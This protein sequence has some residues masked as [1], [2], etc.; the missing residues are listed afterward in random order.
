MKISELIRLNKELRF[1]KAESKTEFTYTD[2]ILNDLV[3]YLKGLVFVY[4]DNSI[5]GLSSFF[6]ALESEA[7]IVLLSSKLPEEFKNRIE[8]IYQP[9]FIV[10]SIRDS[11]SSYQKQSFSTGAVGISCFNR[12]ENRDQKD[13][14]HGDAAQI[15]PEIKILLSTSGTTGSP[16]LVKLS[17]ENLVS[18]TQSILGY[19]PIDQNDVAPLNL[20]IFYSYGLSILLTNS[21]KGGKILVTQQ[22]FLTRKFW[23]EYNEFQCNSF[24]GVPVN[25]EILDRIGFRSWQLQ[26]LKYFTQAGGKLSEMLIEKFTEYATQSNAKF[27]V[28]YGATEATARMSYLPPEFLQSKRGSIGIAIPDGNL[29]ID[30]TTQELKYKGPNVFGGYSENL[31]DLNTW[32]QPEYL[33]TGDLARK[34]EDGF[35][36]ITGRIK[37]IVKLSGNRINLDEIEQY[38][39]SKSDVTFKVIG[40]DDKYMSLYYVQHSSNEL[41]NSKTGV[42]NIVNN[43]S[44]N[45]INDEAKSS[46]KKWLQVDFKIHPTQVKFQE[47]VNYPFTSNGKIDY[48][49]LGSF[50][51]KDV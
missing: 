36:F 19:L 15:S 42:D 37:R 33:A 44:V 39:E 17:H 51:T 21:V 23:E 9:K 16:K 26:K 5:V 47:L 11:I 49:R 46:I 14:M 20:P 50:G 3:D 8:S 24:A 22:D 32:I 38:L 18:N 45:Q 25:Y 6:S 4:S 40:V 12:L 2:L 48:T 27:F 10:D 28:M 35:Y 43:L 41:S 7:T 34:D 13:G 30:P 29:E 1:I 31:E